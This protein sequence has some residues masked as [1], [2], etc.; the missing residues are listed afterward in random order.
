MTLPDPLLKELCPFAFVLTVALE[1]SNHSVTLRIGFAVSRH[2]KWPK[3]RLMLG[4]ERSEE[5]ERSVPR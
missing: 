1:P 3:Y 2:S 5:R 4:R